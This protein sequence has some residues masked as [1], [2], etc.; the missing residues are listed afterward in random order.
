MCKAIELPE[1]LSQKQFAH[2][3]NVWVI[4]YNINA[5]DNNYTRTLSCKKKYALT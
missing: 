1:M 5:R 4:W 3:L 2:L